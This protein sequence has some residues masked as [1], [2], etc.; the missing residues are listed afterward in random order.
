MSDGVGKMKELSWK[1]R[2]RGDI[3]CAPACGASCSYASYVQAK[4]KAAEL[5]KTLGPGWTPRVWENL[6]W[7]YEA[8]RGGICVVGPRY[9][10]AVAYTAFFNAPGYGTFADAKSPRR[11]VM[12]A[13]AAMQKYVDGLTASLED[14][15][16][17]DKKTRARRG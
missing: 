2:R 12:L 16:R 3:Y 9:T 17:L 4:Q 11:A 6:G 13:I 10:H 5:A 14:V 1:P 15:R 7:H 8:R